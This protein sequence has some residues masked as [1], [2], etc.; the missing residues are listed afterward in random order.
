MRGRG[1]DGFGAVITLHLME[2]THDL[3]LP[4]QRLTYQEALAD[5]ASP[6]KG[7]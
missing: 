4:L 1:G 6:E 5:E 7:H 3:C 2:F